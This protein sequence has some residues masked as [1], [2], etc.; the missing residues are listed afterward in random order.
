MKNIQIDI[1]RQEPVFTDSKASTTLGENRALLLS[2]KELLL[3]Q[4]PSAVIHQADWGGRGKGK[5]RSPL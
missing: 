5:P 4:L 2:Q 1:R 3:E